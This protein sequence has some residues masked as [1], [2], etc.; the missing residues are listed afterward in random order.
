[1]ELQIYAQKIHLPLF[2]GKIWHVF[3]SIFLPLT[4]HSS[5][6][7]IVQCFSFWKTE[8][9][10]IWLVTYQTLYAA[11]GLAYHILYYFR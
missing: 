11:M 6:I 4:D 8:G 1:M 2:R 3:V 5:K 10:Q 9:S 7:Y